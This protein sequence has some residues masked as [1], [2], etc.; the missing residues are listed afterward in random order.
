MGAALRY[1]MFGEE[2]TREAAEGFV[3]LLKQ[4]R[5]YSTGGTSVKEYWPR[6]HDLGSSLGHETE[7]SCTTHNL[8][9]LTSHLFKWAPTDS[10]VTEWHE[11]LIINGILS[12]I[13]GPGELL[14]TLPLGEA[15]SKAWSG[16]GWGKPDQ[17]FWCCYGSLVERFAK[18]NDGIFWRDMEAVHDSTTLTEDA[19][20]VIYIN[21]IVSSTAKWEQEGIEVL[22][23]GHMLKKCPR[24]SERVHFGHQLVCTS[25]VVTVR[26]IGTIGHAGT[27]RHAALEL[28]IRIPKWAESSPQ[29]TL[30]DSPYHCEPE[31]YCSIIHHWEPTD[32]LHL[33]FAH[34]VRAEVLDDIET[35]KL[36]ASKGHKSELSQPIS[37]LLIG[38]LVVTPIIMG[39]ET[40]YIRLP[41]GSSL[42]SLLEFV[43]QSA[44][45]RKA[46]QNDLRDVQV[47]ADKLPETSIKS[48][49][50]ARGDTIT[51]HRLDGR[52]A[53]Q[54]TGGFTL[55]TPKKEVSCFLWR[56]MNKFQRMNVW[57]HSSPI[58][59][60]RVRV[61]SA[62]SA[63]TF[64]WK[65]ALATRLPHT[66]HHY[67][68]AGAGES[69]EDSEETGELCEFYISLESY[70]LPGFYVTYQDPDKRVWMQEIRKSDD[71]D[72]KPTKEELEQYGM[73]TWCVQTPLQAAA[74]LGI[75]LDEF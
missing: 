5:L 40:A 34:R 69:T 63:Q 71:K 64:V 43:P 12:T 62:E 41:K 9:K 36:A 38:P 7:E 3:S 30:N 29:V 18:L 6:P 45:G 44:A 72:S 59:N 53:I 22:V 47:G 65:Q 13:S 52:A 39:G 24:D 15:V 46:R 48:F 17:S 67:T 25:A 28:R 58:Q 16:H 8:L 33:T 49:R 70:D 10:F 68:K 35:R 21:S 23:V 1:E 32:R 31:K 2:Y 61:A 75:Q 55:F 14:Y 19:I 57:L 54:H 11:S 20:P 51:L 66:S 4:S 42:L 74:A 37:S 26:N 60:S 50:P 56:D 73:A 27:M